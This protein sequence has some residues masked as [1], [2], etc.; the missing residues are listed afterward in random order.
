MF[1][2]KGFC[3]MLQK[4]GFSLKNVVFVCETREIFV[5]N[6]NEMSQNAFL[7]I[8]CKIKIEENLVNNFVCVDIYS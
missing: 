2:I 4:Y 3:F 7:Q 1:G 5:C 8:L 6:Y